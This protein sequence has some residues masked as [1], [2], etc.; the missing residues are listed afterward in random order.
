MG[1]LMVLIGTITPCGAAAQDKSGAKPTYETLVERVK[2]GDKTVDY[3]SLRLAFANSPGYSRGPDTDKEKK[4][5][6]A[7]LSAED[8]SNAIKN[9]DV[10]LASNYVDMEAHYVEYV[11]HRELKDDE[12]AGFHKSILESLLRSIASSGD[13]KSPETAYQVIDVHEEYV[14]LRFMGAGLPKSQSLL[15]RNDH[16]YDEIK[17]DDPQSNQEVTLYFNV[18]IP[19]KHGR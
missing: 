3:R 13:G 4:A 15:H 5:M 18:D 12:L 6:N 11:A 19:I 1:Y 8:F 7:A 17:F 10:V 14:L 9:A 2:A 16:S